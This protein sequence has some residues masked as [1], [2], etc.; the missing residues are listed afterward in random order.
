MWE[1][2]VDIW[3]AIYII[4]M[5]AGVALF[6][7]W[8]RDPQGVPPDEYAVAMLIPIWSGLA[9]L[10]GALGIGIVEVAGES[11]PVYRYADWLVSTPLLLWA[12]FST[13]YFYR[14]FEWTL[15]IGLVFADVIMILSGLLGD[16]ATDPFVRWTCFAVGCGALA[17]MIVV[18]WGKMRRVAYA[19]GPELGKAYSKVALF[20]TVA[21]IGYPIIWAL[22]P[23]GSDVFGT[24]L[25]TILL[26]VL[27]ILSKVGFSIFDLHELR[28][29]GRVR[30]GHGMPR[31]AVVTAGG[32]RMPTHARGN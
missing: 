18:V 4:A 23:S 22:S 8:S 2:S 29:L 3:L 32:Q 13:A 5:L 28:K 20:L 14:P 30:P 31:D 10:A 7:T 25:T 9:Y 21:W 12:L 15:F 6:F 26:V 11:V 17:I 19:Q 27:P 1:T 24:G 16:L